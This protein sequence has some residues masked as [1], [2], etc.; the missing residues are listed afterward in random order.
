MKRKKTDHGAKRPESA[1]EGFEGLA[2][3]IRTGLSGRRFAN[4]KNRFAT[5]L[6][7]ADSVRIALYGVLLRFKHCPLLPQAQGLKP[8]TFSNASQKIDPTKPTVAG[9]KPEILEGLSA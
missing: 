5:A 8:K 9:L 4:G 3:R 7:F 2:D 6:R 1:C